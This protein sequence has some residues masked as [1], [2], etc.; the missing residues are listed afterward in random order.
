[1]L[2][3]TRK[4]GDV[5]PSL[6]NWFGLSIQANRILLGPYACIPLKASDPPHFISPLACLCPT[7]P[8]SLFAKAKWVALA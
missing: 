5:T 3:N 7:F 2:R 8:A 6:S 4:N 1:M